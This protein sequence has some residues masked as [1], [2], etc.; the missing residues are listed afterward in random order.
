MQGKVAMTTVPSETVCELEQTDNKVDEPVE[1]LDPTSVL[2]LVPEG[3]LP[4]D[5][6][7]LVPELLGVSGTADAV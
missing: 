5:E 4:P 6:V 7:T 3:E 1:I 2:E